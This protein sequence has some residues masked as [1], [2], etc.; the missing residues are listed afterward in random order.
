VVQIHRYEP[1]GDV[2]LFLT[3]EEEIEDAC[4]KIKRETQALGEA[5]GDTLVVPLYSTLPPAQQQRI[6]DPAPGPRRAG[7]LPGRKIVV[8]TNIAETSI[9]IDGIVYVVDPGFSKQ[10]VSLRQTE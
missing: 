4:R 6:F 3:G 9:T 1:E 2:L 8:A 10:K 5:V 7:G